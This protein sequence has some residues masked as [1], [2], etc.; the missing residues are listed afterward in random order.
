[1]IIVMRPNAAESELDGVTALISSLALAA[2]VSRGSERT[3]VGVVGAPADKETLLAQFA[4]LDGVESVVPISRSYKLVSREARSERSVVRVND[5]VSF[6]GARL[7]ICAGPCSVESR[8]QLEATAAAVSRAGANVLRGGAF[9][10]RTSPYAFQGLGEDGL[11]FL[12]DAADRHGLAVVTEVL[13][14]RDVELV[15]TYTDVLQIGARNMQNFTLLREVGGARRPVLLKRGIAATIDEWLMAAEYIVAAGNHDVV[16]CE[17][18][19]RSYDTQTRNLLD[20]SAV[21]V[22]QGLT[23]LPVIVDPSHGTGVRALVA[24][25]S[26]AAVAGGADGLI[27]EV[28][29]NPAAAFSDGPQSLTLPSFADLMVRLAP[30]A[31]AVGRTLPEPATAAA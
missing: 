8:E 14:P 22:V 4:G 27:V 21:P 20:L 24:P 26:L 3:I 17:R 18:G 15:A 31:A 16:L 6:G 12:R 9:K 1:M 10:P 13:D 5:R 28:H 23:H 19:I 2:H 30:V 29:P 11:R 25:M 7:A